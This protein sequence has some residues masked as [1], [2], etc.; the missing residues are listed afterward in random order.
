MKTDTVYTSKARR[1]TVANR[2]VAIHCSD[3][4]FQDAFREFLTEGL[5]LISYALIAI[6]G[7]GHFT[8]LTEIMPKFAKVGFQSLSFL[9][10]RTGA[11]RIILVGHEDCLFFKEILRFYFAEAHLHDKQFTSLRKASR[12]LRERFEGQSVELYFADASSD[13]RIQF[14]KID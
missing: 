10:Q 1:T 8:S 3:H 6:P 7:G 13:N 12:A 4:R 2:A 11:R 14:L 5:G 9:I